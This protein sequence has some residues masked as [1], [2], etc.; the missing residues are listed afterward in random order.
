MERTKKPLHI[1]KIGG[2]ILDNKDRLST[3]IEEF[4][5]LKEAKI[6]QIQLSQ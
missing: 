2:D 1:V 5:Q 4:S 3:L 6:L